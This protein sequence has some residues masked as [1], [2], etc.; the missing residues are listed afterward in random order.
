MDR[1]GTVEVTNFA[2]E[3][4]IRTR[5]ASFTWNPGSIPAA[6]LAT[7]TIAPVAGPVSDLNTD[8]VIGLRVGMMIAIKPPATL[9]AGLFVDSLVL[10]ADQLTVNISNVS[11]GALSAPSGTWTYWGMMV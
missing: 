8:L 5:F 9:P 2:R 10:T 4:W 3:I 6:T 7:Y 11:G 1:W